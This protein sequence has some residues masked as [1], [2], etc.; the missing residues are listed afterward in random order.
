MIL[1]LGILENY[2]GGGLLS[3]ILCMGGTIGTYVLSLL[4]LTPPPVREVLLITV[5]TCKTECN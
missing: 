4:L 2:C 3:Q 1:L 5:S